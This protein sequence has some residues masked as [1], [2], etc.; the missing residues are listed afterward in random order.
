MKLLDGLFSVV[1][2]YLDM[3]AFFHSLNRLVGSLI[4]LLV[5]VVAYGLWRRLRRRRP[6]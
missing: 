4:I 2:A 1:R 3:A 6:D 5:L